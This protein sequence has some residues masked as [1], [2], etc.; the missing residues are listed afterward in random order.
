MRN[1]CE[2]NPDWLYELAPHY[3]KDTDF[4]EESK[5]KMPKGK[6]LLTLR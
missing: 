2:I 6:K 3:Y 1:V 4:K 5:P